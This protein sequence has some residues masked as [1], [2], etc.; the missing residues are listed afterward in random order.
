MDLAM[1][2]GPDLVNPDVW[3]VQERCAPTDDLEL[4][5]DVHLAALDGEDSGLV[6]P[7]K[8][9]LARIGERLP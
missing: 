4:A 7:E 2:G 9:P 1:L 8:P 6:F 3:I 5:E